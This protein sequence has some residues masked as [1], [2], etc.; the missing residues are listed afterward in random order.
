[1]RVLFVDDEPRIL[2]GLERMLRGLR[3]EWDMTFVE[4]GEEALRVLEDE[5]CDVV[6]SDMRMPG[7][8][9]ATLLKEV[10]ER[11]PRAV[12]IVLSGYSEL[13]AALRVVP[14]AHQFLSKPCDAETIRQVVERSCALRDLLNSEELKDVVGRMDALP[15]VPRTYQAL[16][17]ALVKPNVDVKEVADIVQSDPAV[18]AKLLQLVNSSFFGLARRVTEVSQAVTYLGLQTIRSLVLSLEVFREFSS[19]GSHPAIDLEREQTHAGLVAALSRRIV[20]AEGR[21]DLVEVAFTAGLL[22]DVGKLVLAS[23]LPKTFAEVAAKAE[24]EGRAMVDVEEEML[25]V[26]HG[27][28]GGYLL[29]LWGMPVPIAEAAANH[30]RP[31]RS[32]STA[33]DTLVAVHLADGIARQAAGAGEER[34]DPECV[35]LLSDRSLLDEWRALARERLPEGAAT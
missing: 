18:S 29:G 34:L 24:A 17:A 13:E 5:P 28:I 6:V 14:V 20:E 31:H 32:G 27:E 19:N 26:S 16:C 21:R 1:M 22:H 8:D 2:K 35:G 25:G 11:W 33:V 7:M 23:R 15:P 12:R 4:S 30:H 3:R 9:G 10:K